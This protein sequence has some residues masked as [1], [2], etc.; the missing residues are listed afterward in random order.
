M[1]KA[2]TLSSLILLAAA[3]APLFAQDGQDE[4]AAVAERIREYY[5]QGVQNIDVGLIRKIF[6]H[7]CVLY[8]VRD[9]ELQSIDQEQFQGSFTED[10]EPEKWDWEVISV[11]VTGKIAS[12]KV[13][14]E[15]ISVRYIDYLNL[16]KIQDE[17]WI[18]NKIFH[19]ERK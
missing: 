11:D 7:D 16:V 13:R 8:Y 1:K 10:R 4:A 6:H 12:A 3:A 9:G 17:W 2:F 15:N 5:F 19:A 14:L 18:V